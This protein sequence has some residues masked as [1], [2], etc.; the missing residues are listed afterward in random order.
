MIDV[1]IGLDGDEEELDAEDYF[2]LYEGEL[3]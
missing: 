3:L 1:Y 2:Y